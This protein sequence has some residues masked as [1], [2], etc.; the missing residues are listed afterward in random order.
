MFEIEAIRQAHAN[1]LLNMQERNLESLREEDANRQV[2]L[3]KIEEL[4]R[5]RLKSEMETRENEITAV[6]EDWRKKEE[7]WEETKRALEES[8]N[9]LRLDIKDRDEA[10]EAKN[11]GDSGLGKATK[12]KLEAVTAEVDS[13][14]AVMEIKTEENR[15]FRQDNVRLEEKLL[16]LKKTMKRLKKSSLMAEDFKAQLESKLDSERFVLI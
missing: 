15:K 13:L 9:N 14:K 12:S 2:Q 6:I 3:D 16:D 10:L 5:Q 11:K 4:W 1:D 7:H 8:V